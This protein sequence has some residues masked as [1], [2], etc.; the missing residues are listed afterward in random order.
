MNK[1]KNRNEDTPIA[2]DIEKL[3]AMLGCCHQTARKI[4]GE[5]HAVIRINRRVLYSV[6]KVKKYVSNMAE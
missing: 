1:T 6:E 4:A 5:A 3:S 2:V